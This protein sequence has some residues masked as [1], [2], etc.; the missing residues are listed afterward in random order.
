MSTAALVSNDA[1]PTVCPVE[2]PESAAAAPVSEAGFTEGVAD[3]S[4]S[5]EVKGKSKPKKGTRKPKPCE[6][7]DE[8]RKREREYARASRVRAKLSKPA[9]DE[10]EADMAPAPAGT[11]PPGGE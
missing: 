8:R 10:A 5:T 6:K 4:A 11:A 3:A 9:G 2:V 1:P 7:C